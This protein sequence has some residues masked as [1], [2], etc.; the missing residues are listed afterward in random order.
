M[1][2]DGRDDDDEDDDND[3][4]D[5]D[6]VGSSITVLPQNV[7]PFITIAMKMTT[8]VIIMMTTLI[9]VLLLGGR[10]VTLSM[11]DTSMLMKTTVVKTS[12]TMFQMKSSTYKIGYPDFMVDE[13]KV[14]A[15]YQLVAI[16]LI[17]D[18]NDLI[19]FTVKSLYCLLLV[20]R[21]ISR[22]KYRIIY[23]S[24][25]IFFYE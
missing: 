20:H 17:Y 11:V 24:D 19:Y 16:I 3:S 8:T 6:D 23:D 18:F 21:I 14:D 2:K 7:T 25:A 13:S 10:H 1:T 4:D 15:V 12:V 22:L 5:D 9:I